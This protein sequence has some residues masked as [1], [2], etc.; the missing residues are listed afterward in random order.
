MAH[1]GVGDPL[2]FDNPYSGKAPLA[3][4]HYPFLHLCPASE[5]A[6]APSVYIVGLSRM[7]EKHSR[8]THVSVRLCERHMC[9]F[10]CVVVW[11]LS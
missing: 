1:P 7:S 10:G 8:K 3:A 4:L 2:G 6:S 5:V 11:L 9:L